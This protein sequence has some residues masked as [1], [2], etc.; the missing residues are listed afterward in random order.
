MMTTKTMIRVGRQPVLRTSS[1][2][3]EVPIVFG[4]PGFVTTRTIVPAARTNPRKSAQIDPFVTKTCSGNLSIYLGIHQPAIIVLGF[5]P[6]NF[7]EI[8]F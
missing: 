4:R 5:F 2:V 1:C 7:C 3:P 6:M 8:Q